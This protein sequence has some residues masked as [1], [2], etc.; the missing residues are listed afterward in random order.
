M[1]S[2]MNRGFLDSGGRKNNH[3]KK[4]S[5]DTGTSLMSKLKGTLDDAT[6]RIDVANETVEKE[7]LIHVMNTSDLGS[8]PSLPTFME[9]LNAMLE[10]GI[11]L[12][13][14]KLH[15][16]PVTAFSKDGLSVI[17]T[18]VAMIELRADVE[19]KD[20]IVVAMP[21]ITEEGH[22]LCAGEKK[23]LIKP[24]QTSRGVLVEPKIGF[25]P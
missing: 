23:T 19:L 5:I 12:V 3:K 22:Y 9:S 16:V 7:K 18:K 21:K 24:S 10:N 8:Y 2:I 13:W 6:P 15:G 4:A 1:V 17:T 25:K 14:V 20:N 11:V